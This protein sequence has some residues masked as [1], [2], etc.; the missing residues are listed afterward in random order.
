MVK[1]SD[2]ELPMIFKNKLLFSNGFHNNLN[3]TSE[4]ILKSFQLTDWA[5]QRNR[6]L[7]LSHSERDAESWL[8]RITNPYMDNGQLFGDLEVHDAN[9]AMKLGPGKAPMGVSAE[10]KWPPQFNEPTNFTYRGFAMVPNP[11]VPETMVNFSKKNN[12][13]FNTATVHTPYVENKANFS[14][15]EKEEIKEMIKEETTVDE[16]VEVK[17]EEESNL[18]SAE[19]GLNKMEENNA[20]NV[21]PEE[22]VKTEEVEVVETATEEVK[23]DE[24]AVEVEESKEADF[25]AIDGKIEALSA[26]VIALEEKQ[27]KFSAEAEEAEE[28]EEEVEAEVEVKEEASEEVEEVVKTEEAPEEEVKEVEEEVKADFSELTAKL[29]K[30]ANALEAKQAAPMSTAE[31]GTTGNDRGTAVIDRLTKFLE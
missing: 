24:A 17:E 12:G 19:R 14:D 26:R 4:E 8:G 20:N 11:E 29:D 1:I 30:L 28:V 7:F 6:S 31:F 22:E 2:I 16:V 5:D 15:E 27:A 21:A 25:S 18:M 3:I 23:E 10:I 13:E 9:L